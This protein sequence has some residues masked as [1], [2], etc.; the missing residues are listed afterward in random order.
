[1]SPVVELLWFADCPNRANARL[2]LEEA[3]NEVAPGTATADV[4][5]TDPL[6]AEGVRFPGWLAPVAP[7]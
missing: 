1:M 3:V 5:A 2:L 4:D 6:V 7:P